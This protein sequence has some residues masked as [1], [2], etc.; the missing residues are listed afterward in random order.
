MLYYLLQL[1]TFD[2][3]CTL[4]ILMSVVYPTF[5]MEIART[6]QGAT[7]AHFA[8]VIQFLIL[9]NVYAYM[10]MAFIQLVCDTSLLLTK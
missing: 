7:G 10:D 8:L 5:V 3:V 4:Q 2:Y 9:L 6:S 1:I